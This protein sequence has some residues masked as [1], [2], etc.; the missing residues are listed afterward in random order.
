MPATIQAIVEHPDW[1]TTDLTNLRALTTGSTQ[2]PQHLVDA[3]E[4]RGV[5]VL[6]VYGSTETCPI[7]V[8]TRLGGDRRAAST[9]L[10]GLL[11]EARVVDEHGHEVPQGTTGEVVGPGS[12]RVLRIL[13]Q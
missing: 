3:I 12:E 2:V 8:Y 4:A 7:A 11:C 9:G 13:G 10:P 1:A 5:P 6:Q